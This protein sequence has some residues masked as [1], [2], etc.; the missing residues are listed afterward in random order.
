MQFVIKS[1]WSLHLDNPIDA[2]RLYLLIRAVCRYNNSLCTEVQALTADSIIVAQNT[3][4]GDWKA[5]LIPDGTFS[6]DNVMAEQRRVIRSQECAV[7][8]GDLEE[9]HAE[10]SVGQDSG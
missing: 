10:E 9:C 8:D 6:L 5:H 3:Y 1:V 2:L 4:E 7:E